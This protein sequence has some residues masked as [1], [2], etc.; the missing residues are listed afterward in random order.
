MA[1]HSVQRQNL[2]DHEVLPVYIKACEGIESD[3][4]KAILWA[5]A[6]KDTNQTG[7]T[8]SFLGAQTVQDHIYANSSLF[9]PPELPHG[10]GTKLQFTYNS[11]GPP[12]STSAPHPPVILVP[13]PV[14]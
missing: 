11:S 3:T 9:K 14:P 12:P 13:H 7:P 5:R 10:S 2:P 4:Y 8:N 6:M 1:M